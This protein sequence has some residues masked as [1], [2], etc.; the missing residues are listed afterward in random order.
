[1]KVGIDTGKPVIFGVLTCL[2][3]TQAQ[4]RAGLVE[5]SH[6]HGIDWAMAAIECAVKRERWAKGEGLPAISDKP[7]V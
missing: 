3:E 1:M 6:N 2:S 7:S 4:Q 5:G